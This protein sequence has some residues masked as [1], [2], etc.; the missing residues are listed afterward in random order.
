VCEDLGLI[1]GLVSRQVLLSILRG[2]RG[3]ATVT[4]D[5]IAEVSRT[6]RSLVFADLANLSSS[7]LLSFVDDK[8]NADS[9]Q[10]MSLAA[11]ALRQGADPESVCRKLNWQEFEDM[12]VIALN[13][14]D[15]RTRKH[16]VFRRDEVR[17]EI[18]VV[19]VKGKLALCVDCKHWMYGW[20]RG[21]IINAVKNQVERAKALAAEIPKY[22]E[23]LM[24]GSENQLLLIPLLV[25]LAD[26]SS[27]MV[28]GVPVV[29]ILRMRTF[30]SELS[31]MTCPPVMSIHVSLI[32]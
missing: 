10:R 1:Y 9:G 18:D 3:G 7:G 25:T 24:L 4:S 31:D 23:K 15:Y 32:D 22:Q 27:R 6:A 29:P 8:V 2:T 20:Q 16:F 14:N 13:S 17:H 30:L 5:N 26:V 11:E 21:R 28:H 19:G 12:T